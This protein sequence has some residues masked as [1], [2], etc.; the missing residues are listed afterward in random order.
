MV[1]SLMEIWFFA[2]ELEQ[3][4]LNDSKDGVSITIDQPQP[5]TV[6][7]SMSQLSMDNVSVTMD[8]PLIDTS[9]AVMSVKVPGCIRCMVMSPAVTVSN[10]ALELDGPFPVCDHPPGMSHKSALPKSTSVIWMLPMA[11]IPELA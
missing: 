1:A 7:A 5:E 6:K 4:L 10:T 11:L 3:L 2:E 9:S 8:E